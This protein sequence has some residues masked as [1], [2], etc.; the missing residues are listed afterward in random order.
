MVLEYFI[1]A[2]YTPYI[3]YLQY[4]NKTP[5]EIYTILQNK[6]YGEIVFNNMISFIAPYSGSICPSVEKFNKKESQCSIVEKRYIKN[7]FNSIHA[8]ALSNLGELTS[9]LLMIEY[10][11]SSKQKGIITKITT[12]FH[13][14]AKGKI[15]ANCNLTSLKDGIIKSDLFNEN[16]ILVCEVFC[17]WKMK[18]LDI[19]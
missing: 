2:I 8:L 4:Q 6:I 12:E 5:L 7:P 13:K 15:T 1:F 17:K 14:K 11:K 19:I 16:N 9:G 10:L 18:K 3:F